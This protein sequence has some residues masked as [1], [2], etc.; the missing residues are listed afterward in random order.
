MRTSSGI[1]VEIEIQDDLDHISMDAREGSPLYDC[2][3]HTAS[4]LLPKVIEYGIPGA[5]E[6]EVADSRG[7]RELNNY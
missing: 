5:D 6:L 1:Y 2:V 3:A 7:C 4:Q